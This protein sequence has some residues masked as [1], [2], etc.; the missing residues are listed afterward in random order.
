MARNQGFP[1]CDT[2]LSQPSQCRRLSQ[3]LARRLINVPGQ[4]Y[5]AHLSKSR[6]G[7]TNQILTFFLK[8][9]ILSRIVAP[10][11]LK[12]RGTAVPRNCQQGKQLFVKEVTSFAKTSCEAGGAK[13]QLP[14]ADIHFPVGRALPGNYLQKSSFPKTQWQLCLRRDSCAQQTQ[15]QS[16]GYRPSTCVV[17]CT[18]PEQELDVFAPLTGQ[19]PQPAIKSSSCPFPAP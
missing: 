18:Y 9:Q 8:F 6:K 3:A 17:W 12:R 2:H 16:S 1:D 19:Q 11:N 14:G 7:I 13:W 15:A 4:Y 5:P 10:T